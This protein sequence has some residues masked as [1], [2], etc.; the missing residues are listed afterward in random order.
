MLE[1]ARITNATIV[2]QYL[3]QFSPFGVSGTVVIA[4]SHLF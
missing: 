4:E 1:A 3:H 2:E